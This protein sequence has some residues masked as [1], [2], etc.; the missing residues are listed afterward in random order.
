MVS[1]SGSGVPSG[2]SGFN[3]TPT[4]TAAD[5]KQLDHATTLGVQCAPHLALWR[6]ALVWSS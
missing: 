1:T 4:A 2:E 5:Q 3:L 6:D